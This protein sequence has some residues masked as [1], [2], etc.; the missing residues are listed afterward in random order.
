MTLNA[1]QF[2]RWLVVCALLFTHSAFSA[3]N[4]IEIINL[5]H[6]QANELI[7]I[8]KPFI[9]QGGVI[10]TQGNQLIIR[11]SETN[12]T[13]IK[14]IIH[15]LDAPL[16]RL[17]IHVKQPRSGSRDDHSDRLRSPTREWDAHVDPRH[18]R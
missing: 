3:N 7:T 8:I 5:Q 16:R 9:D 14:K 13:D 15:T 18:V 10:S 6:R 4:K 12:I 2:C 11:S 17:I 1:H